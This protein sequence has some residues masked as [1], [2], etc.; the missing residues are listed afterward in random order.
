MTEESADILNDDQIDALESRIGY[1]FRNRTLA[2]QAFTDANM[3]R[4]INAYRKPGRHI[5]DNGP[6]AYIGKTAI[7]FVNM[8]LISES[9]DAKNI[10]GVHTEG[11]PVP[12]EYLLPL[13]GAIA[14]D[15]C[16]NRNVMI[17]AARRL[18]VP[19]WTPGLRQSDKNEVSGTSD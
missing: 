12:E 11:N 6:L 14:L 17:E 3:A 18:F 9:A 1:V 8:S 2:N 4:T 7:T 5:A 10:S 16:W 15:S 13:F 19:I